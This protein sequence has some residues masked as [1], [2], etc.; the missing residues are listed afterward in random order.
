MKMYLKYIQ[1]QKYL[2]ACLLLVVLKCSIVN[3]T[4][5]SSRLPTYDSDV[6]AESKILVGF[7]RVVDF[8]GIKGNIFHRGRTLMAILLHLQ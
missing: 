3:N 2:T 7:E 1:I 6:D 8:I 5:N 4:H